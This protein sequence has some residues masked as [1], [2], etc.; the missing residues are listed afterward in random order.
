M[1]KCMKESLFLISVCLVLSA[2][3]GCAVPGGGEQSFVSVENIE[4]EPLSN[5]YSTPVSGEG[6]VLNVTAYI[7]NEGQADSSALLIRFKLENF[8]GSSSSRDLATKNVELSYIKGRSMVH[9]SVQM[10]VPGPGRYD[11][12]ISVFEEGK[13]P[14]PTLGTIFVVGEEG[15]VEMF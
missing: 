6:N 14:S 5:E 1:N 15:E 11:V 2:V 8:A 7:V 9:P 3:S 4:V 13:D 12:E 10:T